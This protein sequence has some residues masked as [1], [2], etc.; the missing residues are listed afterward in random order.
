[1]AHDGVNAYVY[2]IDPD[3]KEQSLRVDRNGRVYFASDDEEFTK[4]FS[5]TGSSLQYVGWAVPNMSTTATVW[6]ISKYL[7]TTGGVLTA[8]VWADGDTK[9]DNAWS[10]RTSTGISWS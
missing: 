9:F 10:T 3:G 2:G 8:Q 1:M 6:R 7:Y 4:L 5:Y